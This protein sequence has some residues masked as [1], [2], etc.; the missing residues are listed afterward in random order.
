MV[1]RMCI[2]KFLC[3]MEDN[4]QIA[5]SY[6]YSQASLYDPGSVMHYGPYAFTKDST[7]ETIKSLTGATIGQSLHLSNADLQQVKSTY[8]CG[9]GKFP[10]C[11][12]T[13]PQS[14][15]QFSLVLI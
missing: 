3:F 9:T 14:F 11:V 10:N 13:I 12:H 8:D 7:K 5:S 15:F 2:S 1:N 6:D 4:F